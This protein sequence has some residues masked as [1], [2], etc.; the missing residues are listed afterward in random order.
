MAK[1]QQVA[2]M[3][4]LKIHTS[5]KQNTNDKSIVFINQSNSCSDILDFVEFH[6]TEKFKKGATK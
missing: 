6:I 1:T 4:F 3:R 2:W 5:F